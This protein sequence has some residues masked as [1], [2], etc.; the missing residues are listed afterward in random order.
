MSTGRTALVTGASD[1]IGRELAR[2][3]AADGFDVALVAR[4]GAALEELAQEVETRNGVTAHVLPVDLARP[5]APAL[6]MGELATRGVGVDALVN[7]AGVGRI[8]PFAE[9]DEARVLEGLQLNLAALTHLT[10]LVLPGMLRRRWGRIVNLSSS[11]ALS[12][13]PVMAEVHA[14]RAYVLSLS[15]GLAEELRGTGVRVTALCPPPLRLASRVAVNGSASGR[16]KATQ[17]AAEIAAWGYLQVKR[18]RPHATQGSRLQALALRTRLV[19]PR[20][21]A[22]PR[23]GRSPELPSGDRTRAR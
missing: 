14:C 19:R 4:T 7:S 8:G 18:G 21:F 6:V 10:R 3:F 5:L 2:L 20:I 22:S 11:T 23:A 9:G 16:G 12:S 15:M 13:G 1:G 17:D